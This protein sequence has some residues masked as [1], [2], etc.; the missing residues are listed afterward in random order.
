[1]ELELAVAA[2][3]MAPKGFKIAGFEIR[4]IPTGNPMLSRGKGDSQASIRQSIDKYTEREGKIDFVLYLANK[5]GDISEQHT[6]YE[7]DSNEAVK[8]S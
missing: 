5:D 4:H 8:I 6:R 1:M 7:W 3:N 2:A